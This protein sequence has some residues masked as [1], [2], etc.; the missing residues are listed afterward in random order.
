MFN[1]KETRMFE[2]LTA[3]D[4]HTLDCWMQP[5]TGEAWGGLVILQEIFGVTDQLK[6]VAAQYAEAG[7]HVAIPALFDRQ[8]RGA[9]FGF[10]EGAS[11]REL[12]L[13]ADVNATMQDV[14]AAVDAL[15]AKGLPVAVMG[16]CWGGGLAIR[17]AQVLDLSCAVAFY[18]TR[19]PQYFDRPLRAP[20]LG[21]FGTTDDHVP[22]EMLEQARA[23]LPEMEV[24][25]YE[26]GH[27]FANDARPAYVPEAAES[28]H[29]R[30]L[31]FLRSHLK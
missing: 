19:L 3:A 31:D 24:H 30:S 14:G 25:L 21:H 7:L 8:S 6:G 2:T 28:A 11:G 18:G 23:A 29:A 9:V 1:A 17:A 10:D 27:A 12:M 15:K 22:P 13:A 16:F 4:G 5:A 26:A 20:V